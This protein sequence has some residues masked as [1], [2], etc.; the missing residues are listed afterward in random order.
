[1]ETVLTAS[2]FLCDLIPSDSTQNWRKGEKAAVEFAFFRRS[3]N[4]FFSQGLST[5]LFSMSPFRSLEHPWLKPI[6][7]SPLDLHVRL[8]CSKLGWVAGEAVNANQGYFKN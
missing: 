5:S 4:E 2:P 1:M 6:A 3:A 8:T 7:S